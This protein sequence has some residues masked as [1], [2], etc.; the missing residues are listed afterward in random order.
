MTDSDRD[1]HSSHRRPRNSIIGHYSEHTM[2][3]V[4]KPLVNGE[5]T[6]VRERLSVDRLVLSYHQSANLST[7][8]YAGC[9]QFF[10]HL[11]VLMGILPSIASCHQNHH[12][13]AFVLSPCYWW[14]RAGC[15]VSIR[16]SNPHCHSSVI[17]LAAAAKKKKKKP[18]ASNT[19]AVNRVAYRNY[20]IVDTLEA[21]ISLLG[22]EVKSIRDGKMNLRDGYVRPS[23]NGRSCVL[24]NVHIG[25]H[26]MAGEYFQHEERRPRDLLVHK[27]EARKFLQQTEQHGMTIVPLKAYFSDNNRVKLQIALCR[28]KNVRDKRA[29][30]KE[31][32]EK[33]ETSRIIKS[34]RVK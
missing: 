4:A 31:R 23:K 13:N 34:F 27:E 17:L 14:T 30:I 12:L 21:G 19:I 22:T 5:A 10:L 33:R 29:T 3:F 11:L 24:H 28:G 8:R 1:S 16:V 18:G 32:D 7:C 15:E 26:N 9:R 25:K 20:E 6:I 2:V